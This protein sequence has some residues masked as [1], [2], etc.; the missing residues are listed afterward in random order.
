M[1]GTRLRRAGS[2]HPVV[3]R[4]SDFDPRSTG[5]KRSHFEGRT[6]LPAEI[7]INHRGQA[8]AGAAIK[9][10]GGMGRARTVLSQILLMVRRSFP[11]QSKLWPTRNGNRPGPSRPKA[12]AETHEGQP[13]TYRVWGEDKVLHGPLDLMTL[14]TWIATRRLSA[15]TWVLVEDR[16]VWQKAAQVPELKRVLAF[17]P[18]SQPHAASPATARKPKPGFTS[19]AL[20][21]IKLF[22]SLEEPQLEA[23]SHYLEAVS[24]PQFS[25]IVRQG[26]RGEAM[27]LVLEGEVRALSIVEGKESPL[28]TIPAGQWFGEMSLLDHGP[29]SVDVIANKD[30]LL[31]K[32][33]S[34]AFRRL[35]RQAPALAIPFLLVLA[36]TLAHRIR[37][38][39]KRFEDSIRFIRISGIAD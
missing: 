7:G 27:Y 32:L 18:D 33:S 22:E 16:D 30:S 2:G 1:N 21:R 15:S 5:V 26:E 4:E 13:Q 25:H 8:E 3:A 31:L 37:R 38:T 34:D 19:S 35:L 36:S 29:R 17:Y 24:C 10:V 12:P 9:S 20:R 11:T 28:A 23:F 14:K 39:N 6:T